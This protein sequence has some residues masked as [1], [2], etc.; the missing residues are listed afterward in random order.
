MTLAIERLAEWTLAPH[1]ALRSDLARRQARLLLLDVI[2]CA[3]A[4]IETGA[5]DAVLD[6]TEDIGGVAQATVIGR[7]MSSVPNAVLANGALIRVLD[8][9]DVM[10]AERDGKLAVA[11]H[12][13]ENIPAA[14]AVAEAFALSGRAMLEAVVLNYEVYGRLRELIPDAGAWDGASASGMAAAA[15]AGRLLGLDARRQAHGLALAAARSPTPKI[16]RNGEI[17][18][19]KSLANAFAMQ[20]GVHSALLA[21]KG[22]TGPLEILDDRKAGLFQVF[23]PDRGLERL[24]RP[25]AASPVILGTHLKSYP[26]IGTSQTAIAAALEAREGVTGQLDAIE[27]IEVTMADVPAVRRQQ[28]DQAR[29]YPKSREAADHSFAFLIAIAILDGELTHRQ[30]AGERWLHDSAVHA[31]MDRLTLHVSD[32]LAAQ[33]AGSMPGRVT[34]RFKGGKEITAECLEPPG[35]SHDEG[36]DARFVEEKFHSVARGILNDAARQTIVASIHDLDDSESLALLMRQ[37]RNRTSRK[38]S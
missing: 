35:R 10:F 21:A 31:L 32:N 23:D 15:M 24:W 33:A 11:G 4:A 25:I 1:D 8:L 38:E 7:G 26:S 18:A 9:N 29:R 37:L 17:S 6:L 14:L 16:V 19:A 3:Y 5:V 27:A 12:P 2:G 28:G 30:F 36:L 34:L 13:S 20:S 22:V